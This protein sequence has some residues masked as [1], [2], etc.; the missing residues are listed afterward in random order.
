MEV[1]LGQPGFFD[2]DERYRRL[3]E[4]GDPLVRLGKLID[5]ELF[6]PRLEAALKRS[7]G[8]KGGRPPYD[9]VLMFK[10]LI[11]QTLYTLSDDATEFQI[12][13]RLSFMRF[14]QLGIEDVVPDA[15]TIWLFREQLTRAGT[16][17]ALFAEFDSWLRA[18][19][20]LAMSGQIID[21]SIIAAPRQRNTEEEKAALKEG[22]TPENWQD[23]PAKLAQKDRDARWTLKRAKARKAKSDGTK[24]KLEIAI[25]VFGYKNHV[26]IDRAH[27]FIRR[28]KATSAAA[29][30]GAQ[31]GAVLDKTNTASPV[32]ADTAYRSK[33]NEEHL[34]ENGRRSRIHFRRQ[35]GLDLTAAQRK[36]NRARSKV[37]SAVETVF[38][39]QKH[40][41]G[42]FIRTIGIDRATTKIGLANLVYNVRRYL[43]LDSR[44]A[45]A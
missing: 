8:S 29:H 16:I 45:C 15:K 28:F 13:D 43:W 44:V 38:A 9:P 5:F 24:A 7:D 25:P 42:L 32:W 40:V 36:A 39:A 23:K 11:L 33:A 12:R 1:L 31:L 2:L 4:T 35:P 21:A 6:R 41:M 18:R 19:G 17:E 26:S 34:A 27:G 3:S 22:R 30:D 20:Y 14:L 10:V 37:R